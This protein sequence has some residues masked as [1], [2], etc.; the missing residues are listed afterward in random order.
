M[1]ALVLHQLRFDL[2]ALRRNR[3]ARVSTVLM[4]ILLFVV[5]AEISSGEH[6]RT[7]GHVVPIAQYLAPG[8]LAFG[9]LAASF[10]GPVI[11]LVTL[12]E[13]GVLKRRRATP[14]PAAVLIA[15]RTLATVAT[16]ASLAVVLL[17]LAQN[18]YDIQV[19]LAGLPAAALLLVVGT[20]AFLAIAYALST[21][22]RNVAAAQP[23]VQLVALPL[24]IV[25]GVLVPQ[26]KLPQVLDDAARLFPLAHL[27]NGLRVA[28]DPARP[29]LR[30]SLDDLAVLSAWGVAGLVVAVRRFSWLPLGSS[31]A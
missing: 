5:L 18:A 19:P 3:Q 24:Y 10:L 1:P 7:A 2:R 29:G 30:L 8:L 27:A 9:I 21:V 25:S 31:A 11:E 14:V 4:P 13:S 20:A 16:A 12:R 23:V 15:G 22:I 17:V 28:L 26:S 6:V